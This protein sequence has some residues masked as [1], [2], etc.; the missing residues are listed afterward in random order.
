MSAANSVGGSGGAGK[1]N[2]IS[3]YCE[4]L[5]TMP[6]SV[7]VSSRY[8]NILRIIM[9]HMLLSLPLVLC[10]RNGWCFRVTILHCNAILGRGQHRHMR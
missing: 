2:W 8:N 7:K 9:Y 6:P 4:W 10:V 1:P 5:F 3:R